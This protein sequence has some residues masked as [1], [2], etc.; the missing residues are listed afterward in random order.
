LIK[1]DAMSQRLVSLAAAADDVPTLEEIDAML[2]ELGR[3][4][5]DHANATLIDDLLDLRAMLAR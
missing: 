3:L 1:E 4:P 2:T 5:H